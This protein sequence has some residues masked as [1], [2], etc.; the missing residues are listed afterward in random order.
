MPTLEGR[1]EV[2]K[3]ARLV[4]LDEAAIGG[5]LEADARD[6]RALREQVTDVLFEGQVAALHRVA[7]ASRLLPTSLVATIGQRAFGPVLCARV[8]GLLETDRAVSVAGHLPAEFLAD[9][10]A[11]MDPRRA[12]AVIG[13]TPTQHIVGGARV[14]AQRDEHVV[15]GRFVGYLA[16]DALRACL[17]VLDDTALL[18]TAFVMEGTER[19]DELVAML[20][21]DRVRSVVATAAERGLWPEALYLVSHL[22]PDSRSRVAD[23]AAEVLGG[24]GPAMVESLAAAI[25]RDDLWAPALMIAERL[26]ET[27]LQALADRFLD[28]DVDHL[29]PA[30][31]DA[32]DRNG[33][34]DGGFRLLGSLSDAQREILVPR[35]SA[36]PGDVRRRV[37]DEAGARDVDLG[38]LREAL[39]GK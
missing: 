16:A 14:L 12:A 25:D 38:R 36:L 19:L 28:M 30:V 23:A 13:A 29:L 35:A 2:R 11:E 34:W 21:D 8:A 6:V 24:A 18:S 31:L 22:G 5:L 1:A 17:R 27:E 32:A 9:V 39:G 33:L 20:D 4:E 26:P 15:M 10:A 3:L 7:Q 37:L